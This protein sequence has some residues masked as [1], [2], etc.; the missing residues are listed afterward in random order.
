[1]TWPLPNGR[2]PF[3]KRYRAL[4]DGSNLHRRILVR[5][6]D[7]Q[8]VKTRVD[9]T[10]WDALTFGDVVKKTAESGVEKA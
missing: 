4:L 8:T 9:R 10:M 2:A 5:L 1:V 6:H 3:D 7:G